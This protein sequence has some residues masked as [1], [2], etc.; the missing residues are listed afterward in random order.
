MVAIVEITEEK[1]ENIT[2]E[3]E[4]Q[5]FLE[6]FYLANSASTSNLSRELDNLHS[7]SKKALDYSFDDETNG[8]L[9]KLL[10]EI[11]EIGTGVTE[12]IEALEKI[13]SVLSNAENKISNVLYAEEFEDE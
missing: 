12:A 13:D 8:S 7:L 4:S 10:E 1:Y 9:E 3:L 2:N 5:D 6:L 11:N